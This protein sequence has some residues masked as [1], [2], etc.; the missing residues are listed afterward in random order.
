[1]TPPQLA[2]SMTQRRPTNRREPGA[3]GRSL[4]SSAREAVVARSE[5]TE[6]LQ[7][8]DVLDDHRRGH[9][10][11]VLF[12]PDL[13]VLHSR[14]EVVRGR[15]R[16]VDGMLGLLVVVQQRQQRCLTL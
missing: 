6:Q 10:R 12:R 3:G 9:M 16:P 7:F 15:E 1:M 11:N 2:A 14:A 4:R 13:A 8:G 5:E